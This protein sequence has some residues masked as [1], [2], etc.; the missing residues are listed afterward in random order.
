MR[1]FLAEANSV[2]Q[3]VQAQ[4]K[5]NV[6]Q[7]K[8]NVYLQKSQSYRSIL[9]GCLE[10]L[11]KEIDN[12]EAYK[13]Y[14]TIFYSIECIWHLSEIFLLDQLPFN[15]PVPYLIDWIRFHFPDAEQRAT[16]VFFP[17]R[18]TE[19]DKE[20]LKVV[21]ALIVQGH[22]EVARTVMQLYSRNNFNASLQMAEEILRCLPV[23]NVAGGV[24]LQNWR[25]QWQYWL[26][27]TES[28]IQ[29]G[30]FELEPELK[31]IVELVTGNEE[32]W[33]KLAGESSCWFELFPGWLFYT[34]P[35]CTYYQLNALAKNWLRRWKYAHGLP[36]D[37]NDQ[38]LKYLDRIVLKIMQNDL[39]QVLRDIQ[40][41][42]DQQWFAT[43]LTDLLWHSG[44][45]N[46]LNDEDNE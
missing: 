27:D 8:K 23:F 13:D 18:D 39:H 43:H 14:T 22:I 32:A 46:I 31:E 40:H 45:L 29:M 26:T 21:K 33:N 25:S 6:S 15:H 35:S 19:P 7:N 17:I 34:Q 37:N 36:E 3:E 10:K 4:S 30:C 28:K 1:G 44:K 20:C 38:N 5:I 12:N 24:S 41:M 42:Y 11:Q 9:R 16:A 2:F